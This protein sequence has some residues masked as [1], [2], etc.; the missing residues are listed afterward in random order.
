MNLPNGYSLL[1]C[2][3][4]AGEYLHHGAVEVFDRAEEDG[5][6]RQVAIGRGELR[7]PFEDGTFERSTRRDAVAV[8][9]SCEGCGFRDWLLLVQH[10][11]QTIVVWRTNG[12]VVVEAFR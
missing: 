7:S 12:S 6:G 8:E 5:P 2:P 4:C 1:L 9:V 11:G 3:D 10:K